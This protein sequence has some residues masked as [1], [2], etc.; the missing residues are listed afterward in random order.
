LAGVFVLVITL[1]AED[2]Y[3]DRKGTKAQTINREDTKARSILCDFTII[4]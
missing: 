3:F 2:A 1:T 4:I